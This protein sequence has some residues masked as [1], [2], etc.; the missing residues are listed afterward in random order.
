[1]PSTT[2]IVLA[3]AGS[4]TVIA[5][6]ALAIRGVSPREES[7]FRAVN[8]LSDGWF[9]PIAVSMQFGTYVTTPVLAT[10]VWVT[11]RRPEAVALFVAGTASWLL[12][13]VV[14][15]L[16]ERAR[17]QH[18]LETEVRLR[19][20]KEGGSGYPSGHAAT[21][22]AL[23]VTIGFAIG[24]WWVPLLSAAAV[25]TWIGR[26]YVGVHLPLDIA[27]GVGIGLAVAGVTG[28]VVAVA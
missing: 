14:K 7:L 27:G 22:T 11:G 8:G 9:V 26:M 25:A 3:I 5:S 20:P 4:I 10:V 13:K 1:M 15:K 23:A 12:A 2:S 6:A 28:V 24:G 18:V 19:G 17:P 16:A 21:S